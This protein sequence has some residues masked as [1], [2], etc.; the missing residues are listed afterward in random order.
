VRRRLLVLATASVVATVGC[1]HRPPL[2][3]PTLFTVRRLV[4]DR[5][6]A[7]PAGLG[8]GNYVKIADEMRLTLTSLENDRREI[9]TATEAD[10]SRWT[11]AVPERLRA[12]DWVGMQ[13]MLVVPDEP[14]RPLPFRVVG[15]GDGALE[16]DPGDPRPAAGAS[17]VAQLTPL[18]ALATRDVVGKPITVPP[19]SVLA[20]GVGIEPLVAG[21]GALA[22][23]FRV[24]VEADG[25][26]DVVWRTVLDPGTRAADRGWTD[27]R[28]PLDA[29]AGRTVR[30]RFSTAP[31][32]PK[33]SGTSL[34]VW[35]DP[36]VLAPGPAYAESVVLI[37]LDTLRAKSVGT[38]GSARPTTPEL[39]R[40]GAEGVVFDAAYTPAPH[41]LPAHV[42][43][44]TGD[45][46]RTH[47]INSP[48]KALPPA[49]ETLTEHLRAAGYE[50]AAF[51]E[52]GFVMPGVG[53]Q[54]GFAT[55]RE[56]TSPNLHE[57]LGQAAA[58]FKNGV[59]WLS[60]HR[61]QPTF[62]FL[63]TYQVHFPYTP[64]APYDTAFEPIDTYTDLG[65]RDRLRYEQEARYLDDE[66]RA[67]LDAIDGLG[68]GV[69][70]L[71][72]VMGDHGEE[73]LEHGQ[74]MHG[75]AL[76]DESTHVP[77]M[78]RLPGV[79][80]AGGRVAVPVSL[81]D[82]A[83][84]VLD[85]VGA[86]PLVGIDGTSL[87]PLLGGTRAEW[88]RTAVFGEAY[89]S[90]VARRSDLASAR[91]STIH[92]I[93][94]TRLGTSECFDPT[95]DPDEYHPLRGDSPSMIAARR[96]AAT[97]LAITPIPPI[98]V[99]A[100]STSSKEREEKLRALGYVQ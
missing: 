14:P 100:D 50:T 65:P 89:S 87:V 37:S 90:L 49:V 46:L 81:V 5:P 75:F 95:L 76:Y 13:P 51:T 55:Y 71:V 63:H 25:R 56:N 43:T 18:P 11:L 70:T 74:R 12:F 4:D 79:I 42:S 10:A 72:V 7:V 9:A 31:A 82:I 8:W 19:G 93:F 3:P 69:R 99:T 6:D 60:H 23:E 58:T 29:F 86:R 68:L 97:Y 1:E 17:I 88:T 39:D 38:Y 62:L 45:Y 57:P 64:P 16:I 40:F 26:D 94:Y 85:L 66:V 96:Q 47:G 21:D 78:M 30:F 2:R 15:P 32:D 84:T 61:D 67:L 77:L 33:R 27:A 53:I 20:F 44:F 22:V 41:T 28:V 80:P 83:P 73:F 52:D 35:A 34:P 91:L 36:A 59:G 54:R 98:T 24:A 92:C 48:L